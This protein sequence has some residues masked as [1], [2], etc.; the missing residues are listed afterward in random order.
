V[1]AR[2]LRCTGVDVD[3]NM[4]A[5]ASQRCPGVPLVRADMIDLALDERF[6]VVTCLFSSIAYMP[7]VAALRRAV[8]AMARHLNPG[9]ALVVEPW[10][11]PHEWDVGHLAVLVIDEP[12]RKAARVS[13]SSRRH[14]MSVLDF[15][16]VV[17]D[18]RGTRHFTERHEL[19]LFRLDQYVSAIEAA[20]LTVTT[21]DYGLFGRGLLIGS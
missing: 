12:D 13:R 3:R 19:R 7:T 18:R 14:Q 15:D 5:V 9:G 16:Y 6:D 21:D 10:Y 17:A 2:T 11:E 4:L 20:G 8:A 1:F